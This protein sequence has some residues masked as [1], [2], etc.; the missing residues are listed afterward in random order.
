MLNR[1]LLAAGGV[2]AALLMRTQACGPTCTDNDGDGYCAEQDDCDDND[3]NV[4]PGA[5]E[6]C[7]SKDDNCDGVIPADEFDYDQDGYR[8]C[9]GDCNDTN[10][11][12]HPNATELCNGKDDNCDGAVPGNELDGDGD[13]YAACQGDCN[14]SDRSI[15]PGASEQ[16][17]GKD[18]NCDSAV[19][20]NESDSDGDGFRGCSG[21]CNDADKG[22]YPGAT[23]I[24]DGHDQDCDGLSDATVGSSSTW[25][26]SICGA[27]LKG[28]SSSVDAF[29]DDQ[30]TII[31]NA[32]L[33]LYQMWF[34]LVDN[35]GN[36][37]GRIGYA[38]SSDG[39]VW[40]KLTAADG[41]PRAVL[42]LGASGSWD[43]FRLGF[44]S[45]VYRDGA[46]WMY[47]QGQDT[48]GV[49]RIGLA[50]SKDGVAWTRYANNPVLSAGASG[51]WD[52]KSIQAPSVIYD[53]AVGKWKMWY[54]G[55]DGNFLQTGYA[56]SSDGQTWKKNATPV[57]PVGAAGAWDSGRAIFARVHYYN[58]QYQAYY[59]GD[60][61]LKSYTYEIGYAYSSD[62]LTWTKLP[63]NPVFSFGQSGA[64]DSFSAYAA[65]VV[66]VGD[67]YS[68]F[69]SGGSSLNGPYAIG[70][71]RKSSPDATLL[72][73]I[74]GSTY[75]RGD[76]VDFLVEAHVAGDVESISS[77]FVSDRDGVIGSSSADPSG[78]IEFS[79]SALSRGEHRITIL[80]YDDGGLVTSTAV[81][82][83]ID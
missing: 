10:K 59:S 51:T 12:I 31:F 11:A 21:D 81:L 33:G 71:A 20:S 57:I 68:M 75:R 47:Y 5:T 40:S 24:C 63:T 56:E 9:Q 82:L 69:Y 28:S 74:G 36:A 15:Y 27:V 13:S 25:V 45:V 54:T 70:L 37:Q 19:P 18:D 7:D 23:E 35:S 42:D 76:V 14:D 48:S 52:S 78:L 26:R 43:A 50:T 16:C 46:Y 65:D 6:V 61:T 41:S 1:Y 29:G 44:P 79:T 34:R 83:N 66:P 77:T 2:M 72:A 30:A 49:I 17:N 58:G 3:P 8:I 73:P 38:T 62:G 4:Y 22:T 64:F 32:D 67:G 80:S 39:V 55:S 53:S 60:D